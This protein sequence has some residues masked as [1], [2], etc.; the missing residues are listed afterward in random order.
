MSFGKMWLGRRHTEVATD[1]RG[2]SSVGQSGGLIIR[3][4]VGSSPTRPTGGMCCF[5]SWAT[6]W[7]RLILYVVSADP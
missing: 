2:G 5:A 7:L 4:V 3:Q 6:L 1:F